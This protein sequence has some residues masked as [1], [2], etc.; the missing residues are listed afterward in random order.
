MTDTMQ[1]MRHLITAEE[2]IDMFIGYLE[3]DAGY[4]LTEDD[5]S[6]LYNKGREVFELYYIN[7]KLSINIYSDEDK[8]SLDAYFSEIQ[9]TLGKMFAHIVLTEFKLYL[10]SEGR[11][12]K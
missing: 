7:T 11:Q 1:K 6:W 3:N 12:I 8:E 2:S 10:L 4:S 9:A 5:K